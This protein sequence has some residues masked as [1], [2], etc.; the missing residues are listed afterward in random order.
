MDGVLGSVNT[1]FIPNCQEKP[2]TTGDVMAKDLRPGQTIRFEFGVP[3]N[4]VRLEIREV[5][6][7]EK[8]VTLTGKSN[9]WQDDYHF[10]PEDMVEVLD[11]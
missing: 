2:G 6:V 10:Q 3:D 8:Q 1:G 5:H 7:F 11:A 9:G 4:W